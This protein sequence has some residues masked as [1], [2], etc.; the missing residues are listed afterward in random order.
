MRQYCQSS[1]GADA[2]RKRIAIQLLH[3]SFTIGLAGSIAGFALAHGG[4]RALAAFPP[5]GLPRLSEIGVNLQ[6]LGFAFGLTLVSSLLFGFVPALKYSGAG[7]ANPEGS[8]IVSASR[9]RHRAR[10]F[11]VI[12]QIALA[13]VL[14]I[15]AGLMIRTFVGLTHVNPGFGRPAELQ[16]FRIAIPTS[17]VADDSA[18]ARMEQQIQ[19][20][21]GAIPGVSAVAFASCAPLDQD[22]R[23]DNVFA[24]DRG[25][26]QGAA[27][28]VRHLVF[29]SPGYFSVLGIPL[30]AG[31]DLTWTDIYNKVP[32]AL[33]SENFAREY[34][35]TPAEAIGKRIRVQTMD[36]WSEI[37]GVVGSVRDQG[38]DKP[39]RTNVY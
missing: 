3:E 33:I 31:C 17:D 24:E 16:T 13:V 38:M 35:H 32:V 37:I 4:L 27:P 2:S 11:L 28:P 36:D 18:V 23:F 21:L 22:S 5:D 26:L 10:N 39:A 15:C 8:R 9:E 30:L 34:W 20:K 29:V 19:D 7:A 12:T 25:D 1:F 14:L 6:V